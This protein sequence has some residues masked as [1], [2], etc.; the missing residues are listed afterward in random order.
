MKC[1]QMID[2]LKSFLNEKEDE[3]NK[4]EKLNFQDKIKTIQEFNKEKNL[5]INFL[6][7]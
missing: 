2:S 3:R 1:F 5:F 6:K 4:E 7:S